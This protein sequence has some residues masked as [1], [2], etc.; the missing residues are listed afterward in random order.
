MWCLGLESIK[1]TLG[2]IFDFVKEENQNKHLKWLYF[3]YE[4]VP[5]EPRG[6]YRSGKTQRTRIF[7]LEVRPS[8]FKAARNKK[9]REIWYF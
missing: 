2:I 6:V 1:W 9:P 4:N 8:S 3:H 7:R 5:R